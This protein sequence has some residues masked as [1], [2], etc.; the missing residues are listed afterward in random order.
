MNRT[1]RD[2][3]K[4]RMGEAHIR[5]GAALNEID[6]VTSFKTRVELNLIQNALT[7]AA[8]DLIKPDETER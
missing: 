3:A 5:L 1:G 6:M 4:A 7:R 2:H 8:A